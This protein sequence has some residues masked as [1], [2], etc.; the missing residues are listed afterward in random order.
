MKNERRTLNSEI[1][2]GKLIA[3]RGNKEYNGF[4]LLVIKKVRGQRERKPEWGEYRKSEK[5]KRGK[6]R[7][8]K[9]FRADY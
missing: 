5:V 6:L 1:K 2:R 9:D 4:H 8:K 3:G 7:K